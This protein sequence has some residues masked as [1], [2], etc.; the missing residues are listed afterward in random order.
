MHA[1]AEVVEPV[2]QGDGD[3][4]TV[5][6]NCP[7]IVV[8]HNHPS[9]DPTPSPED[10]RVTRD[11]NVTTADVVAQDGRSW[12]NLVY[13]DVLGRSASASDLTLQ[14]NTLLNGETDRIAC[15]ARAA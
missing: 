3:T 11:L 13:Q 4:G 10:V 12:V 6:E 2:I 5:K 9:G 15:C 14:V 7:A 1:R 8:A